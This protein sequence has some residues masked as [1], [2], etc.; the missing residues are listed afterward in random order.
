MHKMII[1]SLVLLL[2]AVA[3]SPAAEQIVTEEYTHVMSEN[4]TRNEA[5][6]ICFL[7]VKRKILT[8]VADELGQTELQG[9]KALE[10]EN[11]DRCLPVLLQ[12]ET[13]EEKWK[14]LDKKL[15]VVIS[16]RTV[17]DYDYLIKRIRFVKNDHELQQKIQKNQKQLSNFEQE[18]TDLQKQLE[19]ADKDAVIPLRKKRQAISSEIDR[20]E[21]VKYLITSKTKLVS[22]KITTGMTIDEVISFAGQPRSTATCEKPDFLNYGNIWIWINNG[23]VIGK[24]PVEKWSG[25][26]YRYSTT[27]RV[28]NLVSKEEGAQQTDE[29]EKPKYAIYLKNGQTVLTS[30]Y[31]MV[32]DIIYYKKY[33]GIIGIEEEKVQDIKELD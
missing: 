19:S 33:G 28:E 10:R 30:T 15:A 21:E 27:D 8:R 2:L 32:N 12:I 4:E 20:L 25:P 26:C 22:D 18:Y 14:F 13:V 16:A 6:R 17:V 24:I 11:I 5:R 29:T 23:I 3:S 1:T 9:K 7:E 31:Y